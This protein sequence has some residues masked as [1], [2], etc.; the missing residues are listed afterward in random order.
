MSIGKLPR[1][2]ARDGWHP[3]YGVSLFIDPIEE[4]LQVQSEYDG[5]HYYINAR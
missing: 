3:R 2:S 1:Q 4:H 5:C